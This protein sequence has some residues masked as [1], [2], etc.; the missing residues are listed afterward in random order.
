MTSLV[1]HTVRLECLRCAAA[2]QCGMGKVPQLISDS[3]CRISER[4]RSCRMVCGT[5][6]EEERVIRQ[7][8]NRCNY[9][10]RLQASHRDA[11]QAVLQPLLELR[12]G[13]LD[14]V[15]RACR[16]GAFRYLPP[17]ILL[18]I[19]DFVG[20]APF[21]S[22]RVHQ[23]IFPHSSDKSGYSQDSKT[24]P[25]W[26]SSETGQYSYGTPFVCG[27]DAVVHKLSA[28]FRSRQYWALHRPTNT[29]QRELFELDDGLADLEAGATTS[30]QEQLVGAATL[31][32]GEYSSQG[33]PRE[34]HF[35]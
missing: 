25:E 4:I 14:H 12:K 30:H 27:P 31:G 7:A 28:E 8:Q 16:S 29:E 5:D 24:M 26:V 34:R 33:R 3:L 19:S 2:C 18:Y 13:P 10:R 15:V 23:S 32:S 1:E 17:H 22:L 21:K 35:S 9:R 20:F 6:S 11:W